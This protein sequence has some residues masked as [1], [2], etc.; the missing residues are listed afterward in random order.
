[1]SAQ[2]WH[3]RTLACLD[4]QQFAEAEECCRRLLDLEPRHAKGLANLGFILQSRGAFDDAVRCYRSALESDP[5]LAQVW[6]NLGVLSGALKQGA[7]AI[8]QLRRA[9][10]LEPGRAEWQAA[11]GSAYEAEGRPV[12]ALACIQS[13]IRLD[14]DFAP[15]HES[16]GILLA[17]AG[18]AEAAIPAFR[19]AL[20]LDPARQSISSNLLFALNYISSVEPETVFQEHRAWAERCSGSLPVAAHANRADPDRRLRLA[21]VSPDFRQNAV[22]FFIDPVLQHRDRSRF[23]VICYSDVEAE[24]ALTTRLLG[25]ADGWHST[26]WLSNEAF[27][28]R[29]RADA[30]DILVDLAGHTAGGVRMPMYAR[31]PAPVQVTWLGYLNTTGLR[32]MDYR[33]ADWHACPA[34]MDRYHSERVVR[35][36]DSQWCYAPVPGGPEV[37]PLPA[38]E[39]GSITFGSFANLPK[40]TAEVIAL[41]SRVL[42]EVPRS[43]MV[44]VGRGMGQLSE[45]FAE[46]FARCG[47]EASRIEFREFMAMKEYLSFHNRVDINLDTFPFTGGTTSLHSLWMGVPIVSLAGRH[48]PSRGGAS[49]LSVLGM[50]EL[51]AATPD[52]YVAIAASL[53]RDLHQLGHLRRGLRARLEASPLCDG[54]RFARNIEAAYRKMWRAWC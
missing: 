48:V 31:K 37:G 27:A 14:A 15:A 50:E 51:I 8:E 30:I 22:F 32:T 18:E 44:I 16:L 1:M 26:A 25:M 12:E 3:A 29:I 34:E 17:N 43:R 47:V 6:Y 5:A 21:Y 45:R 38:L 13:A 42:Q 49:I 7:A 28:E 20:A 36:P 46:R 4:A 9:T 23:E 54:I 11:L 41:W 24:D 33:L 40:V 52:Q 39:T 10:Q 2:H 19:R 53:A 35:L